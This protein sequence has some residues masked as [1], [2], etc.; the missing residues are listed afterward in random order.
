MFK[1][2]NKNT[3]TTSLLLTLNKLMLAGNI[4]SLHFYHLALFNVSFSFFASG[5]CPDG[6]WMSSVFDILNI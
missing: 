1:V 5:D 4:L 2:N 3:R 6:L